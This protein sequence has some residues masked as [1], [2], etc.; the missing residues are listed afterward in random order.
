MKIILDRLG[1]LLVFSGLVL[2][3]LSIGMLTGEVWWGV[4][5]G[6]VISVAAGLALC[7][8]AAGKTGQEDSG[9]G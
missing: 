3:C 6:A 1:T 7:W 9:N 4:L 2:L 8:V 5:T